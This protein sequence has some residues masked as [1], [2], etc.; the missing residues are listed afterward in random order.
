M[1]RIKNEKQ[2]TIL[3]IVAGMLIGAGGC[4]SITRHPDGITYTVETLRV[5]LDVS[6]VVGRD[7][8]QVIANH[9][10]YGQ[11]SLLEGEGN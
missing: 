10:R 6:R 9:L 11:M 8:R 1:R 2:I 4:V 7:A 5:T 3:L